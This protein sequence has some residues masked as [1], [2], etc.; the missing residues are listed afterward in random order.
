MLQS[1]GITVSISLKL[2]KTHYF[3]PTGGCPSPNATPGHALKLAN[4]LREFCTKLG[5][6]TLFKVYCGLATNSEPAPPTTEMSSGIEAAGATVVDRSN[7]G[8]LIADAFCF[9]ADN[10]VHTLGTRT[11][12]FV[13]QNHQ[14]AYTVS[15]LR[16]RG[17]NVGF[18]LP[19][20]LG[21]EDLATLASWVL[22]W[23]CIMN[24]A[25]DQG[26]LN[27]LD[28]LA[29]DVLKSY[30]GQVASPADLDSNCGFSLVDDKPSESGDVVNEPLAAHSTGIISQVEQEVAQSQA[31]AV[32][33]QIAKDV[34][35]PLPCVEKY[36][37]SY[38]N[39]GTT[40]HT[41]QILE[42]DPL[43]ALLLND[44]EAIKI[45]GWRRK[46][47]QL[48]FVSSAKEDVSLWYI[49]L[50]THIYRSWVLAKSATQARGTLC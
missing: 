20:G 50:D 39:L 13:T 49:L 1:C 5:S 7:I 29:K 23:G 42:T 34:P 30:H 22:D 43:F 12:V 28:S 47:K 44:P 2:S 4:C 9:W 31:P 41:L 8:M 19:P 24:S 38:R 25:N 37:L 11:I 14:L 45:K 32:E 17:V 48:C 6:V 3:E 36:T 26:G 10:L 15:A 16:G 46:L 33:Y 27:D 35:S 21:S 18:V 40:I